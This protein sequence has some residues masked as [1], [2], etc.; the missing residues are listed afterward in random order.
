[1]TF[2]YWD[3]GSRLKTKPRAMFVFSL[4]FAEF[5]GQAG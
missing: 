1:M 3:F 2:L 5:A 4:R